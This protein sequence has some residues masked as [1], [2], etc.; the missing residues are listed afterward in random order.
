MDEEIGSGLVLWYSRG[1]VTCR[2]LK[3]FWEEDHPKNEYPLVLTSYMARGGLWAASGHMDYY[4]H[5]IRA[6]RKYI[7]RRIQDT[8][9]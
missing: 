2:V 6:R 5:E 4:V 1:D 9:G 8:G 7:Y 3:D